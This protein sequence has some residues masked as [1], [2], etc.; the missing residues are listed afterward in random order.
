[1]GW[2]RNLGKLR[3]INYGTTQIGEVIILKLDLMSMQ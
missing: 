1:M 3:N 2:I